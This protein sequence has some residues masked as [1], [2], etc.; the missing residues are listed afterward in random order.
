M[1]P[2]A[3]PV[4][5]DCEIAPEPVVVTRWRCPF[6]HRSRAHKQATTEHIARCWLNPAARSCKT[7][8]NYDFAPG[9]D[10]CPCGCGDGYAVCEAGIDVSDY[11]I[12]AACPLW[13]LRVEES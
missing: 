7:C 9:G 2:A 10:F 4:P 13:A 8:A 3:P 12:K 5:V 6:C 11:S 1:T